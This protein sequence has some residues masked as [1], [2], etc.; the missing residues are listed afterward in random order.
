MYA[1]EILIGIMGSLLG[2]ALGYVTLL[3][4]L[5]GIQFVS[6]RGIV[7]VDYGEPVENKTLQKLI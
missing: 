1:V 4:L 3:S 6:K 7:E 2:I 5:T